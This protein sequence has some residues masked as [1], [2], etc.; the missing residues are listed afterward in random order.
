MLNLLVLLP[1]LG[2]LLSRM[3][4]TFSEPLARWWSVLVL[5]VNTVIIASLYGNW[6]SAVLLGQVIPSTANRPAI[7]LALEINPLNWVFALVATVILLAVALFSIRGMS[8]LENGGK[9]LKTYHVLSLLLSTSVYGFF[10]SEN[11][12]TLFVFWEFMTWVS[13]FMVSM[14]KPRSR[15]AAMVFVTMSALGAATFLGA[16]AILYRLAG[17]LS[18]SGLS[19]ALYRQ[20]AGV[21]YGIMGLLLFSALVKSGT[22]PL[23]TWLRK[24]HGHA[25]NVFS[26]VLSGLLTKFGV[27]LGAIVFLLFPVM[28]WSPQLFSLMGISSFNYLFAALGAVSILVG[29]FLAIRQEDAKMLVAYSSVSHAGYILLGLAISSSLGVAGS[30]LHV[31]NHALSSAAMFLSMA[32]VY[33]VAGTTKMSQLGGLVDKM[34][35]T[36]ATYLIAIIS[37]AGI[38]PMGGFVSKW[39]LYQALIEKGMIFLATAA[40]IGSIGSFLYVFTPLAAVFLGQR[41]KALEHAKEVPVVMQ[42]PMVVLSLFTI[43]LGVL[44][45]IALRWINGAIRWID[46]QASWLTP[47]PITL[48]KIQGAFGAWDSVLVFFV[49][50]LGV[51]FAGI[52]FYLF[53]KNRR[54]G[55]LENY[56]AGEVPVEVIQSPELYHYS[57]QFYKPLTDMYA[58][59]PSMEEAYEKGIAGNIARLAAATAHIFYN[60]SVRWSVFLALAGT[61]IVLGVR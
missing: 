50:G 11:L 42:I 34:P 7:H 57:Y 45:S 48:S 19:T 41:P 26:P 60:G 56:T 5:G 49:F 6:G 14:G 27:F 20:P 44:P 53:R 24:T 43:L 51:V 54:V 59:F 61:M 47:I 30:L 25:P 55:Y 23:H 3:I 33:H 28:K 58:K 35:V 8:D 32:A 10:L 52:L 36:F 40:F 37:T 13:F 12:L 2:V 9:N 38:P 29:T 46:P 15:S 16:V 21:G 31:M 18:I 1:L 22:F 17:T 39:L 4:S